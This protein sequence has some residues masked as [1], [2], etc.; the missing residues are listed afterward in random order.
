M[1]WVADEKAPIT[2][3]IAN[4]PMLAAGS[5]LPSPTK[6]ATRPTW[7]STIQ[8]LRRPSS[9]SSGNLRRS[10]SGDHRNLNA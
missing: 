10:T 4:Q 5:L 8:L 7:H 9:P 2:A 6:A 3:K 1:S